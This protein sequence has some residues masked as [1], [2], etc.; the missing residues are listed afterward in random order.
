MLV[1]QMDR[2]IA[3][4]EG[5]LPSMP[6]LSAEK[7]HT[8][9]ISTKDFRPLLDVPSLRK[10]AEKCDQ[11]CVNLTITGLGGT[12]IEPRVP[13]MKV[14]LDRIRELVDFVGDPRRITWCYSPILS[15][16]GISNMSVEMFSSIAEKMSLI[17]VSRI[18]AV[19]FQTYSHKRITP[20]NV[21]PEVKL[22]FAE[23]IDNIAGKLGF[24]VS[25]CKYGRLHRLKCVDMDYFVDVHPTKDGSI[26]GHYRSFPP[27]KGH[28]RDVIWDIGWYKPVCGHGCL[29]C[30][31][32]SK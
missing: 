11:V 23:E 25:V 7:I 13:T 30:Y 27:P 22:R 24:T 3:A 18:M 17:G 26:I 12:L 31:G 6:T 8:L 16:N 15:W 14:M 10:A 19:F 32:L 29:Y 28:C 4:L 9:L 21:D 1:G 20:D 2:L 5:R